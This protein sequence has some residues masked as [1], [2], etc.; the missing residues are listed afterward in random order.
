M[1]A[2]DPDNVTVHQVIAF[3]GRGHPGAIG[4]LKTVVQGRPSC[5]SVSPDEALQ[6]DEESAPNGVM[7]NKILEENS[8]EALDHD[9]AKQ[10]PPPID[11]KD[12]FDRYVNEKITDL[13]PCHILLTMERVGLNGVN[14]EKYYVNGCKENL[15]LF[16]LSLFLATMT[17]GM[18][19]QIEAAISGEYDM[20]EHVKFSTRAVADA[21]TI[22]LNHDTDIYREKSLKEI[23][24]EELSTGDYSQ[25]P[26]E[27][28]LDKENMTDDD[29]AERVVVPEDYGPEIKPFFEDDSWDSDPPD[30][31]LDD[32]YGQPT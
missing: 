10:C 12:K 8:Q 22:A 27:D 31:D 6:T 14:I 3:I 28:V 16:N 20:A 13:N 26:L 7:I 23:R 19:E 32:P 1:S 4:L 18:R 11:L 2:V 24:E 17:G 21:N 29:I 5:V 25:V 15:V 30:T 9:L